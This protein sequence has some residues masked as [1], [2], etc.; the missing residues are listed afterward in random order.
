MADIDNPV[1]RGFCNET[2]RPTSDKLAVLFPLPA[3]I[4]DSAIGKG[5]SELL[6]TTTDK[7]L[8]ATEWTDADYAAVPIQNIVG[9]DSDNRVLLTNHDMIAFLRVM[10]VLRGLL[11][12]HPTLPILIGKLAVNPRI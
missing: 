10:V 5:I 2:T 8:Q 7:L 12:L 6:G 11:I 1:V 4:L 3:Q 9:T